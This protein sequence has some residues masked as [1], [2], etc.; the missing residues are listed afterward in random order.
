MSQHQP[1]IL[2]GACTVLGCLCLI[3]R[4]NCCAHAQH[5]HRLCCLDQATHALVPLTTVGL[6][7]SRTSN[8]TVTPSVQA[9]APAAPTASLPVPQ[10]TG[11]AP[12]HAHASEPF[13][14]THASVG[15]RL[16]FDRSSAKR[17]NLHSTSSAVAG[18][19][20]QANAKKKSKKDSKAFG[21]AVSRDVIA[22]YKDA[23]IQNEFE[24][25]VHDSK[26]NVTRF[27]NLSSPSAI[28]NWLMTT[29]AGIEFD[30]LTA[31]DS[32]VYASYRIWVNASKGKLKRTEYSLEN[33]YGD[34]GFLA[35]LNS[36]KYVYFVHEPQVSA[37]PVFSNSAIVTSASASASASESVAAHF[38]G[39]SDS[40][41][42]S[43]DPFASTPS[44][45]VPRRRLLD[46]DDLE[47][48]A[49]RAE[50][51][52]SAQAPEPALIDLTSPR[53]PRSDSPA[54]FVEVRL[55]D[56]DAVGICSICAN[57][58]QDANEAGVTQGYWIYAGGDGHGICQTCWDRILPSGNPPLRRDP[59]TNR[60]LGTV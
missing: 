1:V 8:V 13:V 7:P 14:G 60:P 52:A 15:T 36:Y 30:T 55:V 16:I 12:R 25:I 41:D 21:V 58:A 3:H 2:Y 49:A 54:E 4:E 45:A 17:G 18:M 19:M 26:S 33:F 32:A 9:H 51:P 6:F 59:M 5:D 44:R 42:D 22:P 28:N 39:G 35:L 47:R 40:E 53:S 34:T 27:G 20:E 43:D 31:M 46:A 48:Y 38:S 11:L 23:V 10:F 50:V 56:R 24:F 57:T 29:S 37:E